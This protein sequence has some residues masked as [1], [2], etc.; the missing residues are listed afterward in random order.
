MFY[1]LYMESL[2]H[3][4]GYDF[5]NLRICTEIVKTSMTVAN[6]PN[7]DQANLNV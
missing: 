3:Q 4:F 2:L 6:M 7:R 1:I 5:T